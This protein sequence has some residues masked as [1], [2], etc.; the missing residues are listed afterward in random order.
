MFKNTK[1]LIIVSMISAIIF[2]LSLIPNLG[3]ITLFP[4]I[5]ITIIHIPV[6]VGV[7]IV[8]R[9]QAILLGLV[10]GL[11]SLIAALMRAVSPI[12]IAFYNPLISVLPRILFAWFA[13]EIFHILSAI[14]K[15]VSP[16]V[17]VLFVAMI[18]SFGLYSLGTYLITLVS[19]SPIIIWVLIGLFYLL[20]IFI[21]IGYLRKK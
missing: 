5:S 13:Y 16:F 21:T 15:K 19:L 3:F 18:L 4:G 9:R 10:F 7:M 2:M 1:E 8:S 6:L 17:S 11:G 14:S 20:L 12:E